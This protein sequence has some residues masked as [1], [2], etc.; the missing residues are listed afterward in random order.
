MSRAQVLPT[1]QEIA[2]KA[3]VSTKTV[4]NVFRY[5]DLVREKTASRVLK[6]LRQMGIED[7]SAMKMKLRPARLPQGLSLIHI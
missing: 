5:P 6:A 3:G 2:K 4:C 7:S 1:Y